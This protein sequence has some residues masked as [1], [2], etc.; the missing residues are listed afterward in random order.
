[1][2]LIIAFSKLACLFFK[3]K[4]TLSTR[5]SSIVKNWGIGSQFPIV[6]VLGSDVQDMFFLGSDV[7]EM[8]FLGSNVQEMFILV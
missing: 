2:M 1:M 8:F 6:L 4:N 3:E 7:Q 5:T